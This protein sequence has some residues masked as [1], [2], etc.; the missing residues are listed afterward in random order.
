MLR[1]KNKSSLGELANELAV[2]SF[3]AQI[4]ILRLA[5]DRS[6]LKKQDAAQLDILFGVNA[7]LPAFVAT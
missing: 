2:E 6:W 3:D 5:Q 4:A 7:E 1:T